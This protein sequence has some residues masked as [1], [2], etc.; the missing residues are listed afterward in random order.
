VIETTDVMF[1]VDSIPAVLSITSDSF[2]AYTSNIFA[3]LGL[4]ALYFC[5]AAAMHM[6]R[7]LPYALS[8][9]LVFIGA[10]MLAA[11]ALGVHVP[12]EVMLLDWNGPARPGH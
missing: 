12:I 5:L 11:F 9:I 7:Y 2:I 6:F 10:K 8:F 4:R 3:I 1:A